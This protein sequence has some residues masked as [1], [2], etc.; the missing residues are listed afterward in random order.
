MDGA[1][2]DFFAGAGFTEDEN[3]AA[4]GRDQLD[5]SHDAA[6][7]GAIADNFFKI[8]GAANFF[9]EI[10]FFFGEFGLERIDFLEGD[11]VFD[12][13]GDLRGDLLDEFNLASRSTD[14]FTP[15]DIELVGAAAGEI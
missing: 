9:L 3:G 1:R 5:L 13:N 14:G 15:A 12:G 10:E 7:R 2:D 11:G 8:V 4:G 6:N